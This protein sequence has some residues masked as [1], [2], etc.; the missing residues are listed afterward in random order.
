MKFILIVFIFVFDCHG[1]G[2]YFH[3]INKNKS[4]FC[5]INPNHKICQKEKSKEK[6]KQ[7]RSKNKIKEN[8]PDE[9]ARFKLNSQNE[10]AANESNP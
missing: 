2:T 1:S 7:N 3:P 9:D 4:N 8:G 10:E 6:S 5:L